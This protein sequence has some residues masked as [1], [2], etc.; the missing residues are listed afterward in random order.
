MFAQPFDESKND[1]SF[2]IVSKNDDVLKWRDEE[3]ANKT[4]I[5]LAARKN[6]NKLLVKIFGDDKVNT[7][8]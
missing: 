7:I 5:H 8:L 6:Y 1:E 3:W 4:L 2:I